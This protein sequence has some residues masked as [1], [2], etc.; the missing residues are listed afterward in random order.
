MFC[1][2]SN[3]RV[4][5]GVICYVDEQKKV[6]RVRTVW[7]ALAMVI[8][9]A[10]SGAEYA[11]LAESELVQAAIDFANRATFRGF[12]TLLGGFEVR[13]D[14]IKPEYTTIADQV[15]HES[16]EAERAELIATLD[17]V[18][19]GAP[20]DEIAKRAKLAASRMVLVPD[21]EFTNGTLRVRHRYIAEGLANRLGYIT[22][23]FLDESR[24]YGKRL[25]RC[26]LD[27][28]GAFFWE[29]RDP[30]G[31]QPGRTYCSPEHM[32]EFHN[33]RAVERVRKYRAKKKRAKRKRKAK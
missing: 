30:S 6:E 12:L 8:D 21:Y 11:P 23:L 26:K 32:K 22:L 13:G 17:A 31:G 3:G 29:R 16:N 20:T 2:T 25:C 15:A 5:S 27:G 9:Q 28:C 14:L 1:V 4:F 7:D 10:Q 18:A 19:S 24:D 33:A